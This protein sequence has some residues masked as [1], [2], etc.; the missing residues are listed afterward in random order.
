[1]AR[2]YKTFVANIFRLHVHSF[3]IADFLAARL[4]VARNVLGTMRHRLKELCHE[5]NFEHV[6]KGRRGS[7]FVKKYLLSWCV[8]FA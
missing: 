4:A 2:V 6:Q 3:Q 8:Q 1:M 7:A 5:Y